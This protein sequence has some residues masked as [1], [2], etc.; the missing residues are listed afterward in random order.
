MS[1]Q[2]FLHTRLAVVFR[3]V[4]VEDEFLGVRMLRP[5]LLQQLDELFPGDVLL[6]QAEVH[7]VVIVRAVRPEDVQPLPPVAHAHI[8]PLPDQQPAGIEQVQAPDRVA[9]VHEI[10]P[11]LRPRLPFVTPVLPHELLLLRDVGLPEEARDVVLA[12]PDPVEQLLD[13]RGRVRHTESLLDPGA[14][15]FGGVKRPLGDL[16]LELLDL[17]R[18]EA[19]GITPVVQG[20]ERVQALVAEDAEPLPDLASRDP[21]QRGGLL[22]SSAGVDPKQSG[23]SLVDPPV[24]SVSPSLLD[25]VPLLGSQLDGLHH[26]PP[27]HPHGSGHEGVTPESPPIIVGSSGPARLY[28]GDPGRLRPAQIEQLKQQIAQGAFHT[29]EQVRSWVQD[30]FGVSYSSTG[31][32][33]LLHRIGASYHK[34]SGFFWKADITKQK[35]FVRK[36][37]RHK[38]EAGP[39]TRRYFVDACHPV[40]GLDLLYSCWLLVGQRFYVG[41]GNGRKRLNILG[42]Y[43]PDDHDYVDLRLT[44]EN[45]TGE[46]FV[47]P[48]EALRAKH[49]D[50]EKFLLYLDNARYYSKPC[51]KE[52]L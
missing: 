22:P 32:K 46:Q 12:G 35:Q 23:Q 9:S 5:H 13:A 16:L 36:Y 34:V 38:R 42:A 51:V 47:K 43:S 15:L 48:L 8:E 33:E 50:T 45:V 28:R 30:T 2:P 40:W 14:D 24:L 52:W 1:G 4:Q 19:T 25:F 7:V 6:H 18:S 11:C 21:Q 37:R 49:P 41:V 29:A 27:C 44:K 3:I 39:T 20:A 10:P 26:P 17:G 31:I